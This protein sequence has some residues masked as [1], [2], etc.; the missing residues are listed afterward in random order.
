[1]GLF[2]FLQTIVASAARDYY[3]ANEDELDWDLAGLEEKNHREEHLLSDLD[4][5]EGRLDVLT[6]GISLRYKEAEKLLA[7]RE[8]KKA[9][10]EV[11]R[12]E[13]NALFSEQTSIG[14][15][16]AKVMGK[17]KADQRAYL[18][19]EKTRLAAEARKESND[20]LETEKIV[21]GT[22]ELA[23]LQ[24]EKEKLA[25]FRKQNLLKV[26]RNRNSRRLLWPSRKAP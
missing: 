16:F 11:E 26:R 23:D 21:P 3:A 25:S 1:M 7:E 2:W 13:R 15:D 10:R 17:I 24:D 18:E 14:S 9:E 6:D 5:E 20:K 4:A 19:H 12:S 8:S 22:A